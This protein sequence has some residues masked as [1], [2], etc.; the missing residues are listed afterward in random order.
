[1]TCQFQLLNMDVNLIIN[2]NTNIKVIAFLLKIENKAPAFAQVYGE[3][4]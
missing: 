2:N 3:N 1:M 4:L